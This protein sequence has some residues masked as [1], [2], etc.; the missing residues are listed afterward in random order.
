[1]VSASDS[2]SGG[3]AVAGLGIAYPAPPLPMAVHLVEKSEHGDCVIDYSCSPLFTDLAVNLAVNLAVKGGTFTASGRRISQ[4]VAKRGST[5]CESIQARW[6]VGFSRAPN[7]PPP[8][9]M[10]RR[11]SIRTPSHG[12]PRPRHDI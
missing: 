12:P 6:C 8:G 11:R 7:S 5:Y 9:C 2:R 4:L 3:S 10:R 1:M